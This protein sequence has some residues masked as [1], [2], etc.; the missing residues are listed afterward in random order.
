MIIGVDHGYGMMKTAN[1]A[2][3]TGITRYE[4]EPYSHRDTLQVNAS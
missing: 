3:P 4:H 1:F 2:F